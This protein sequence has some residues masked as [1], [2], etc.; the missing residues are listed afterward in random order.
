MLK[1]AFILVATI[2]LCAGCSR[3]AQK[4]NNAQPAANKA[5]PKKSYQADYEREMNAAFA[6]WNKYGDSKSDADYIE[7]GVR[8][9]GGMKFKVMHERENGN[10]TG[11][12]RL[13]EFGTLFMDW[14]KTNGPTDDARVKAARDEWSKV[15]SQ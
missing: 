3:P 4:A 10:L 11:L 8:I 7:T 15:A 12:P 13:N 2:A 1:W 9:Y 6:A 14:K 5:A